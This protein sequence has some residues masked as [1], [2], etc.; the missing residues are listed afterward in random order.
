MRRYFAL[1]R[2]QLIR[3]VAYRTE[4]LLWIILDISPT[5][6]MAATWFSLYQGRQTIAGHTLS[7]LI[8]YYL[9]VLVVYNIAET[10]FDERWV[11]YI[12]YG[13]IDM[14]LIKPVPVP[15]FILIESLARKSIS[16]ITFVLPFGLLMAGLYAGGVF[17]IPTITL[18]HVLIFIVF[19]FFGF[20]LNFLLSFLVVMGAFWFDE[21]NGFGHF[22]WVLSSI[23]GGAIAPLTLY[24]AWVQRVAAILP[25]QRS[26]ATPASIFSS[27]RSSLFYAQELSILIVYVALFFVIAWFTW[28]AALRRYT[29][30][31]G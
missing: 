7:Q 28:K 26:L 8:G 2:T 27:V 4:M 21:A 19:L 16:F 10:H 3:A 6:V 18:F 12:R 20:L 9:A 11:E 30:A 29:S 17:H 14:H 13:G 22:R 25:F 15:I 5:I 31:G 23:F 24:P 1:F